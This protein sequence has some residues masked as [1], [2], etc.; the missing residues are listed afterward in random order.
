MSDLIE[1]V[2]EFKSNL[3][4]LGNN[5]PACNWGCVQTCASQGGSLFQRASCLE[6]CHCLQNSANVHA[7]QAALDPQLSTF[8][9]DA[10]L[11]LFDFA[12]LNPGAQGTI[13]TTDLVTG[14][15][16]NIAGGIA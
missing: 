4:G 12:A 11:S 9:S 2:L 13:Q 7:D 16:G 3:A 8:L 14:I 5:L 1:G 15:I 6:E 10:H